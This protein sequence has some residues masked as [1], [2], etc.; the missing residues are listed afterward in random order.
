MKK[1]YRNSLL[2]YSSF[3][4]LIFLTTG[5][6]TGSTLRT[7]RVL[8]QGQ[9][10]VSAGL[11]GSITP[12]T[13]VVIVAYGI[14]DRIEVEGRWEQETLA[15]TPRTQDLKSEAAN[16]NG[17]AFVEFGYSLDGY[18][19][20]GPGCMV[21]RRWSY[22][23]P[24]ISYQFRKLTRHPKIK[25]LPFEFS[26]SREYHYVKLGSRIYFSKQPDPSEEGVKKRTSR[27]FMDV[28]VGPTFCHSDVIFEWGINFGFL[29]K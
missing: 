27:F 29:L 9:F 8:E 13:Q 11:A 19:Q 21:G 7:A 1:P 15:V 28:E 20:W 23:E 12:Q 3:L 4:F 25:T 6:I 2:I 18:C 5:C 17:L 26:L 24:Y 16:L 14:T 22:L 10:E